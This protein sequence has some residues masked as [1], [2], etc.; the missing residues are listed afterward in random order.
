MV[1]SHHSHTSALGAY[2]KSRHPQ[3]NDVNQSAAERGQ[4]AADEGDDEIILSAGPPMEADVAY[5]PIALAASSDGDDFIDVEREL[6]SSEPSGLTA[7]ST[8]DDTV[9]PAPGPVLASSSSSVASV[10]GTLTPI[11]GHDQLTTININ[12]LNQGNNKYSTPECNIVHLPGRS[13]VCSP[14]TRTSDLTSIELGGP[15][16]PVDDGRGSTIC[17]VGAWADIARPPFP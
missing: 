9:G 3:F 10:A 16:S 5:S 1:S 12:L 8:S 7:P 2:T 15:F 17:G 6:I 4:A 11:L 13:T 14:I